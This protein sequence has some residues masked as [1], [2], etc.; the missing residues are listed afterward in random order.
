[1]KPTVALFGASVRWLAQSAHRAGFRVL[2]CDLFGDEDLREVADVKTITRAEYPQ[3]FKRIADEWIGIPRVYAGGLENHPDVVEHF[4]RTGPLWGCQAETLK[5]CR[6]P[7]ALQACGIPTPDVQLDPEGVPTDGSW[8]VKPIKGSGGFGIRRWRGDSLPKECFLQRRIEGEPV[9]AS[10]LALANRTVLI[11]AS[12][13]F[14]GEAWSGAS[15]FA[16]SGG[17][18][19]IRLSPKARTDLRRIGKRLSDR[20]G[21]RGLFGLDAVRNGDEWTFVEIN[22]RPMASMEL[23]ELAEVA[24]MF[25]LHV[26][27]FGGAYK[28]WRTVNRIAGKA[29]VFAT[30]PCQL[31]E[32]LPGQ[33]QS[34]RF[35]DRPAAGSAFAAGDPI[36]TVLA[37]A[38][39]QEDLQAR[40]QVGVEDLRKRLKMVDGQRLT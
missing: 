6:T 35:A 32:K 10:Y 30:N 39:T 37:R 22:P 38:V 13:Q 25:E 27:S 12:L 24:S 36:T 28:K 34:F 21:L 23:F 33:V 14:I 15:E 11:G 9:S 26:A 7:T 29:I 16:Y 40:L 8:L 2:A 5:R 3:G 31:S 19:P 18:A 4:E 17:M 20:L 1:M